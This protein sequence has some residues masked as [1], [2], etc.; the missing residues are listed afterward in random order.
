MI[1]SPAVAL[2]EPE[3]S[4]DRLAAVAVARATLSAERGLRM[5][6]RV[7]KIGSA[8]GY[9]QRSEA[10]YMTSMRD[11][12]NARRRFSVRILATAARFFCGRCISDRRV[13]VELRELRPLTRGRRGPH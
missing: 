4:F 5:A 12:A 9:R 1:S 11:D 8:T 10:D 3:S 2:S 6:G 13:H 7:R